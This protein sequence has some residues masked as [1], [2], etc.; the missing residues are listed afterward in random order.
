MGP[1]N[2]SSLKIAVD[3]YLKS[4]DEVPH[5]FQLHFMHAS[6]ILG[7]KHPTELIRTWWEKLYYRLA[8]DM[9]LNP[10][11]VEQMDRRL[12]DNHDAWRTAEEVVAD[13]R[14]NA[15]EIGSRDYEHLLDV[16]VDD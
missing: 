2:F 14:T 9:H 4:L 7:Y 5:H 1:C 3:E 13:Q 8:N 6:E 12:D 15:E 16:D 10:E 11:T